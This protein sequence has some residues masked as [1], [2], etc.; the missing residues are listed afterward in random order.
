MSFGST[1]RFVFLLG[2]LTGIFLLVGFV[3]AGI[4]GMTIG[5]VLAAVMNFAAYWFSD[6]F[7]LRLYKAKK[8][9]TKDYPKLKCLER[10]AKESNIPVPAAYIIDT[11]APNAFATGRSPKKAAVAVTKGL[12][13]NLDEDEVEGVIA[14]ELAHI[15]NHDTLLQ[16]M[17]ATLAG[18]ITWLG[19]MFY[20]GDERNRNALS[21]VV[22]F[23]LAPIAATL[24]R[25]AISRNREYLA[26]RTGALTSHKPLGLADAL[27]KISSYA[28]SKPISGN[29][30]TSHL[31]IVNPFSGGS[32]VSLFS[33]HPPTEL[34]I[35]KLKE[36]AKEIKGR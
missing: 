23:I 8:I 18:A 29:S 35:E 7:V 6:S 20:F 26:D 1:M 14:H 12:L 10:L 28:K 27:G 9:N 3:F 4:A 36:I 32:L 31:F 33:T 25:L 22:L 21:F 13:E 2:L 17:S 19:Y 16:T 5:L 34:R 15:K 30:S 11:D 24:I